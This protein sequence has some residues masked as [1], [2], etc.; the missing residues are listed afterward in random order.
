MDL[1]ERFGRGSRLHRWFQIPENE[2]NGYDFV[3]KRPSMGE[4]VVLVELLAV[5]RGKDKQRLLQQA[6]PIQV[7]DHALQPLVHLADSSVI[8]IAH[9]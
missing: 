4:T 6:L 3:V 7:G 8:L 9:P 2:G 1:I 5:I